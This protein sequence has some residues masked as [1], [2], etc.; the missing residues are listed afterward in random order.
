MKSPLISIII[1]VYN[2]E[3]TLA[4]CVDSALAQTYENCEVVIVDDGTPDNAGAIADDYASRYDNMRVVHKQNAGLAEA[5]R[6]GVN[7]AKGDYIIHLDSDDTMLPDAVEYLLSKCKEHNL[8]I[9]YGN[10]IRINEDG[11]KNEVC[12]PDDS[13]I[14]TGE[15]FMMYNI[16]PV[17]ICANWGCLAKRE[18][19]LNDSIY[20]PSNT[21]LPSEDILINIKISKFVEK[22]GLFNHPVCYYYYN[23]QSLSITGSLSQLD[24]WKQYFSIIENE[25]KSRNLFEKYES[26][27]LCMKI[28]SMAFYYNGLDTSDPWVKSII[29]DKRF[30]LPPKSRLLQFLIQY[31]RLWEF[32]RDTKRRIFN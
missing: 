14:L 4:R 18:L 23:S 17:G 6:S 7:E 25:L 15:E 32:L 26:I 1:P 29:K 24:K 27:F 16:K 3:G 9:A 28:E 20:P 12:F 2:T 11:K 8:D 5:R 30:K 21:K 22:I 10:Y 19:W 13:M 31:P